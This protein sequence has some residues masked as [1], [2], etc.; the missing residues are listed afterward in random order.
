MAS[1]L[2]A[3]R[4]GRGAARRRPAR[5]GGSRARRRRGARR[6]GSG[7][8]SWPTPARAVA[9]RSRWLAPEAAGSATLVPREPERRAPVIVPPGPR[10]L[11]RIDVDPPH[12]ALAEALLGQRAAGGRPRRGA[13]VC[14][15]RPRTRSR[16]SRAAG[17]AIDPLGAVTGGSEPPL[18]ET[19]LARAREL[20]ELEHG[21]RERGSA[22]STEIERR[23]RRGPQPAWRRA[24]SAIASTEASAA[25]LDVLDRRRREG[26]RR[27]EAERRASPPSS[28]SARSRPEGW[29]AQ[30]GEV[31]GERAR[32]RAAPRRC[33]AATVAERRARARRRASSA[34]PA[35]A[36][37]MPASSGSGPTAA[38]RAA[39]VAE[40]L[41][42]TE[43]AG[44]RA[45]GPPCGAERAPRQGGR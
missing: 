26:P 21:A 24:T 9:G 25:A 40:R 34:S 33:A 14:G 43:A 31:A 17:E 11:D 30:G 19:L 15:G 1:L 32:D 20:R 23:A 27:L 38:V 2:G 35:G 44:R 8:S 41:H 39:A 37:S 10:L 16:S 12:W 36:R 18:E 4:R 13:R 45:A 22:R 28:R 5:P 6:A 42:A 7:R 3:S 29:R